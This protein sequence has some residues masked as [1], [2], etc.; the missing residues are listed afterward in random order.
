MLLMF[1]T[2]AVSF[3][4]IWSLHTRFTKKE[5]DATYLFWFKKFF[6][7]SI[8]ITEEEETRCDDR[9]SAVAGVECAGVVYQPRIAVEVDRR[10]HLGVVARVD[11][12]GAGQ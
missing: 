1:R 8:V 11:A 6:T 10:D 9:R 7:T 12:R 2:A 4:I 3:I 5:N